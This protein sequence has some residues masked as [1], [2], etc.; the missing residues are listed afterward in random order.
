[1][2]C[3]KE[4]GS[5]LLFKVRLRVIQKKK[6]NIEKMRDFRVRSSHFSLDFPAIGPAVSG[7]AREKVL[8]RDKSC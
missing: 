2:A 5:F 4:R 6:E 3:R 1:M 7:E 8:P